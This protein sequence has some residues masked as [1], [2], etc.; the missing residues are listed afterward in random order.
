[1]VLFGLVGRW[2]HAIAATLRERRTSSQSD[3]RAKPLIWSLLPMVLLHSGPWALGVVGASMYYVLSQPRSPHLY[4]FL[5]GVLAGSL[6]MLILIAGAMHRGWEATGTQ[7]DVP[8]LEDPSKPRASLGDDTDEGYR[9]RLRAAFW[10][11]VPGT[12]IL[13]AMWWQAIVQAPELLIVLAVLCF[14]FSWFLSWWFK[15]ILFPKP[16]RLPPHK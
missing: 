11:S 15:L 5:G 8:S 9:L 7:P 13:S 4:W 2:V 16:W 3:G 6:F 10:S 12:F 1:V 14:L